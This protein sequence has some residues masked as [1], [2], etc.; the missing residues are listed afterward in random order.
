MPLKSFWYA[1]NF[2][3]GTLITALAEIPFNTDA[4]TVLSTLELTVIEVSA[5]H[6]LNAC[7][8]IVVTLDP[9][10]TFFSFVQP[11]NALSPIACYIK[12]IT[13]NF[14]C[15]RNRCTCKIFLCRSINA[16]CS[17]LVCG[18]SYLCISGFRMCIPFLLPESPQFRNS[19]SLCQHNCLYL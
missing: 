2:A 8:P 11:L 17:I 5:L 7:F 18:F 4:P 15:C 14:Y 9:I 12:C 1:L 3:A 19:G 10:V 16:Y 6:P 13:I